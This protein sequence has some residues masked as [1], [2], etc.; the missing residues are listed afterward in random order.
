MYLLA[1]EW[2]VFDM[3]KDGVMK[4]VIDNGNKCSKLVG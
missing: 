4:E 2:L 3:I 1:E